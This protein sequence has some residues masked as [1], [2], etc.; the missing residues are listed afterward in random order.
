[1]KFSE[2]NLCPGIMEA[3]S[4]MGFDDATPIQEQ[5]IPSILDR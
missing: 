1:M 4:Y 3:I 5:A 2:F